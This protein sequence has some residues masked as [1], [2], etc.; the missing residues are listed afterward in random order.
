MLDDFSSEISEI[1]DLAKQLGI[2]ETQPFQM[3]MKFQDPIKEDYKSSGGFGGGHNGADLRAPKGTPIYPIAPGKVSRTSVEGGKNTLGG[4]TVSIDHPNGYS[5][6]Y[7]HLN[8]LNV[9]ANQEVDYDTVIGTVGDTGNAKGKP[10]HLHIEVRNKG[11]YVDPAS[12]FK[13]PGYTNLSKEE[14]AQNSRPVQPK[15]KNPLEEDPF[16]LFSNS[17]LHIYL[18]I[19]YGIKL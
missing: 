5:S 12:L 17:K 8:S 4:N 7:A 10:A 1:K 16:T 3:P 9:A 2:D 14:I 18:Q 15:E 11:N 13:V 6:Y 19:K